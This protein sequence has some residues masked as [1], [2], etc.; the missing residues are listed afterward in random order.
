MVHG[1]T[2]TKSMFDMIRVNG[3]VTLIFCFITTVNVI[4]LLK[5]PQPFHEAFNRMGVTAP[6]KSV[7][8]FFYI[9]LVYAVILAFHIIYT[10]GLIKKYRN[11]FQ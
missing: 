7:T 9:M 11:F 8:S 3:I 6:I 4:L 1:R 5:D 2:V 10:F